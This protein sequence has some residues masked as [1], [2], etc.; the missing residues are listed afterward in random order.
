MY[1]DRFREIAVSEFEVNPFNLIGEQWMLIGAGNREKYN[2]MTASWGQVGVLWGRQVATAYIRP[3]RYTKGFVD[4]GSY[5]TLCFFGKGQ[6][7]NLALCG[8]KSGRDIDKMNI[9]GLSPMFDY[10][11]EDVVLFAE[12]ELVLVCKKLYTGLLLEGG[13]VDTE[14]VDSFYPAKDFHTM[15]TGEIVKIYAK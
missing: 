1:S 8:A 9:E 15:Y 11:Y 4:G 7:E 12:A 6:R 13:F 2:M 5:F 10:D 14:P 3:S